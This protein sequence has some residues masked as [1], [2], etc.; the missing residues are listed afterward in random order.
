MRQEDN[1]RWLFPIYRDFMREWI[2][3]GVEVFL[4]VLIGGDIA[5]RNYC[6]G[7]T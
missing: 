6:K 4:L 5:L 7:A 3:I 2:E 1:D